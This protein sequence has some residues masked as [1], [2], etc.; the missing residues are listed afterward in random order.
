MLVLG[1]IT[2]ETNASSTPLFQQVF[3]H[4]ISIPLLLKKYQLYLAEV[5]ESY[6]NFNQIHVRPG[7]EIH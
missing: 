7:N 2:V 6:N 1:G 4:I 3:R 5:T